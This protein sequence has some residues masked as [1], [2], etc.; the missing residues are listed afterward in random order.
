MKVEQLINY[1]PPRISAITLEAEL[2]KNC[3]SWSSIGSVDIETARLFATHL[4]EICDKAEA[5]S[6]LFE[7]MDFDE[8][9]A[10]V[11]ELENKS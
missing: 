3:I 1:Y 6:K 10:L 11:N 9:K 2:P 7:K 5:M 8:R 4:H